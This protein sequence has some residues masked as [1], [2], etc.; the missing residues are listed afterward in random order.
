MEALTITE[1]KGANYILLELNGAINSYT[2]TEFQNRVYSIIKETNLVLDLSN[3]FEIDSSGMGVLFAAFNDGRE[4]GKRLYL[5]NMSP[6][7]QKQEIGKNLDGIYDT[8]CY[9]HL[10]RGGKLMMGPMWDMDVAFGNIDQANQTCYIPTG[11]YIKDVQWY[12]RLFTDPVFVKR[13]KE[14]F[15]YFN[16]HLND[17]LSNINADAQYLRYSAEENNNVWGVLNVKTWPNYNIWGS[18]QNEVQDVK[19]WLVTRMKWLKTQF[20]KM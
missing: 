13:V 15:N 2:L 3:V 8:S 9:M 6:Q 1:K 17:I 18:Y 4:V 19:E 11:F 12:K 16:N 20:D 14:R 5:M 7:A 10:A